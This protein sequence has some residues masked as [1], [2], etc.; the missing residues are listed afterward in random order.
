MT[1]QFDEVS[2]SVEPR[3]GAG[4]GAGAQESG[5][6]GEAQGAEA[7]EVKLSQWLRRRAWLESR[8]RAD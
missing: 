6:T 8:R 3:E 5:A 1:I 2:G 4:A 7:D